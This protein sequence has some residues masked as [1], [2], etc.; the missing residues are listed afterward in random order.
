MAKMTPENRITIKQ[1]ETLEPL[2]IWTDQEG[3]LCSDS[4]IKELH[5]LDSEIEEVVA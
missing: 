2:I 4:E 5:S 3:R 1:R